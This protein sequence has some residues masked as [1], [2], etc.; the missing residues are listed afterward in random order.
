[1]R[2]LADLGWSEYFQKQ[3]DGAKLEHS[4]PARVAGEHR[5]FYRVIAERGAWLAELAGRLRYDARARGGRPAVGDWVLVRSRSAEDRA[6]IVRVLERKSKFSRKTAGRKTEEQIVA[7]NIDTVFLVSGLDGDFN[8]R[9]IERYL[10]LVWESGARPVVLLNKADLC[11][12]VA[13]RLLAAEAAAPGVPVHAVS[14][15]T[16]AG[17]ECLGR[18]L[19]RGQT[20]AFVG[21]SGVGKST[22]INRLIGEGK[23]PTQP[24]RAGDQR[25]MHTTSTRE[26]IPL[27]GGA[28]VVD[29]PG[30]RELQLWDGSEGFG[31][32]FADIEQ[33]ARQC[34]FTDCSHR[35]EPGCA[36]ADAVAAGEFDENRLH[37]YHKLERE[38]EFQST[39]HDRAV[40]SAAEKSIRKAHKA[41]KKLYRERGGK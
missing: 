16:G 7:A 13:A 5:G 18:Y 41:M 10:T 24:V 36:V 39:K 28:L 30:M 33:L 8:L 15:A 35:G 1:M 37:S 9:R 2:S 27:P 26:L 20:I 23:L 32:A 38:L 11:D 19:L 31:A 4:L 17:F 29:T 22:L 25:G 40:R 12:D 6:T 34:R 21:S 3:L 14:A